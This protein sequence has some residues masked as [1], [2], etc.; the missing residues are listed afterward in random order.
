MQQPLIADPAA[1]R[2]AL[3]TQELLDTRGWCLWRCEALEGH[4]IAVVRDGTVTLPPGILSSVRAVYTDDELWWIDKY[5]TGPARIRMRRLR[6]WH[7]YKTAT[8]PTRLV[9][10]EITEAN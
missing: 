5:N 9:I 2:C 10:S 7:G 3:R 1:E 4:V 8:H 6:A